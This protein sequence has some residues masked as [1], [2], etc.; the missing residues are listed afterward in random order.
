MTGNRVTL[1]VGERKFLTTEDTLKGESFYFDAL[2]SGDWKKQEDKDE[3]YFI[4]SDPEVFADLLHFLRSGNF[5]LY[6]DAGQ[7]SYDY[8]RYA[9]LLSGARYFGIPKLVDWIWYHG[10]LNAVKVEYKLDQVVERNYNDTAV[11]SSRTVGGDEKLEFSFLSRSKK[12]YLCPRLV[13]SHYDQPERCGRDCS[14][15]RGDGGP[16]FEEIATVTT[17]SIKSKH[18]F[19]PQACLRRPAS[20][21]AE[22]DKK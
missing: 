10:Y 11:G 19:N 22:G 21:E 16:D 14:K 3:C 15:A 5:P 1:Q 20:S 18:I 8:A 4:D 6:Y 2:F 13:L 9:A 7:Q 12:A 17:I